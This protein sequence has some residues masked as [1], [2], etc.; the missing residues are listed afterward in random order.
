MNIELLI[1]NIG[2]VSLAILSFGMFIFILLNDPKSTVN[3]TVSVAV[4]LLTV[5][6]LSQAIGSNVSDPIIS[7]NIFMLNILIPFIGI[8][9][10]HGIASDLGPNKRIP[11]FV[12]LMYFLATFYVVIS[13][14]I[15]DLFLMPSQPKMYFPNYYVPGPFNFFRLVLLFGMALPYMIYRLIRAYVVSGGDE[16]KKWL[17]FL[18]AVILGYGFGFI[19]NFLVYNIQINPL[20]GMF[21]GTF[22]IPLLFSA[23][24]YKLF[25]VKI[26]ARQAFVYSVAIGV[27]GGLIAALDYF[28]RM[29]STTY[30]GFPVWISPMVS[31]SIVVTLAIVVWFKLKEQDTLK[32]EFITT[33][34]HK[35]R[36]PLTHIRW[37]A[38]NLSKINMAESDRDNIKHIITANQKLVELTDVLI[39][40]SEADSNGY[41]YNF[42]KVNLNNVT[43]EAI[44]A[45]RDQFAPRT[46][47]LRN[48][49]GLDLTVMADKDKVRNVMQTLIENAIH[50]SPDRPIYIQAERVNNDVVWH[51]RDEGIGIAK[52]DMPYIFTRFYRGKDARLSDTEGMGIGLFIARQIVVRHHGKIWV[53]SDGR[54]KGSTFSFSLPGVR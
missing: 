16:R 52:E 5:Y 17:Y 12:I 8:F 49:V 14:L 3:R 10:A 40:V 4:L 25:N 32:Y 45:I 9:N 2:F 29:V 23:V 44:D 22:A 43:R 54:G 47:V 15:P 19:P 13:V 41:N 36:T 46:I 11:F 18:F 39:N 26:I 28:N 37:A 31:A 30:P 24:K 53:Q 34:T 21:A 6:S 33:V 51:V 7:R 1:H 20:W 42:E 27:I 38:E 50:Y 48:S 35:F